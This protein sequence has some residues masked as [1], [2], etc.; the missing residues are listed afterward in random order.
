MDPLI[1]A[2]WVVSVVMLVISLV[3]RRERTFKSFKKAKQMMQNMMPQIIL[4]L[5]IIG[6]IMALLPQE[7]IKKML[8]EN[9]IISTVLSAIVGAITIIPAFVAFPLVGSLIDNG[10]SVVVGVS[11]LTTLT[12]VG[13]ATFPI[14]KQEFGL[15]FAVLRNGVSFIFA[16]VIA[17]AMGVLL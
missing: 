17:F 7:V 11:F 8:G 10:A 15:K 3:K 14:E 5:L 1:L 9:I 2:M 16:I 13:V 6:Y 12:M 4:I